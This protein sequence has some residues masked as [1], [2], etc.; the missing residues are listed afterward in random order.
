[1]TGSGELVEVQITGEKNNFTRADLNKIL[2]M[3]EVGIK[4]LIDL[5][6]DALGRELVWRVGRI[7]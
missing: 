3:A 4:D 2:D 1:M 5:Q 6:K 7:G